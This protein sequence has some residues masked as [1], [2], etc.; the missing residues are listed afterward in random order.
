MDLAKRSL[1]GKARARPDLVKK[2]LE[3]LSRDGL[4]ATGRVVLNRLDQPVPLGD[5]AILAELP[6]RIVEYGDHRAGRGEHRPLLSSAGCETK[7]WC[8]L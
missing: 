5:K 8:S 3:R 7:R 1:V 6:W 2:V 4:L